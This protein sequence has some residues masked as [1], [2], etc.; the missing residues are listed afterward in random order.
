[1]SILEVKDLYKNF[2]KTQ[3]L[4]GLN[5]TLEEG[6]VLS[7]IGS[8]GSGKTTLLRC[9]NSLETADKGKIVVNGRTVFDSDNMHKISAKER[10][11]NQLSVGLVFQSFNL[12]NN[13]TVEENVRI[14][15]H[16]QVKYGMFSGILRGNCFAASSRVRS[17]RS[18]V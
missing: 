11:K 10:R 15:L 9:I 7:V 17:R 5:F 8:S 6:K 12:F 1:M 18:Y 2:G 3:V 4:K 14:G 16:N 13:M